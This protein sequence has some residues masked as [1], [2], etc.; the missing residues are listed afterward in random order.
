MRLQRRNHDLEGDSL[1]QAQI[2]QEIS[3]S[4]E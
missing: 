4:E 3:S 2:K 1:W